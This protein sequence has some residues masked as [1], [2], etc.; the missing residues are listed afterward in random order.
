MTVAAPR[1]VIERLGGV[2]PPPGHLHRLYFGGWW[3][4]ELERARE[5][6][7]QRDPRRRDRLLREAQ[8]R[9]EQSVQL[10][11]VDDQE[12]TR[13]IDA[14]AGASQG[15]QPM[16]ERQRAI[17]ASSSDVCVI[18]LVTTSPLV[19]GVGIDHP[20]EVGFAFLDPHGIAYLP[21]SSIKGTLR[22]A[23]ERLALFG[24]RESKWT[25][26]LV[27]HSFG[28][29]ARA[30]YHRDAGVWRERYRERLAKEELPRVRQLLGGVAA[31][32][33]RRLLREACAEEWPDKLAWRG[34]LCIWDAIPQTDKLGVDVFTP[35][36]PAYYAGKS[37]PTDDQS[38]QP[39]RF[40]VVQP[41]VQLTLHATHR[42]AAPEGHE[43]KELL[44]QAALFAGEQLGFG[45]KTA[46]GY[47]RAKAHTTTR[48]SGAR[49][50]A[51]ESWKGCT[52]TWSAGPGELIANCSRGRAT[53]ARAAA[54]AILSTLPE[55]LRARLKE[56]RK[57]I[58]NLVA[59]VEP[60]GNA[61]RLLALEKEEA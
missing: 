51:H 22:Q 9:R 43:W 1:Y 47:G 14:A 41:G 27:W 30:A 50:P 4:E 18:D 19:T 13:A 17:A 20:N 5:A 48:Q 33:A 54:D 58:K 16:V 36:F 35:H 60:V 34:A 45:A 15:W 32:D 24:E 31:D 29:D 49:A 7:A 52:V 46:A 3:S 10:G 2:N 57:E 55:H 40:L 8:R 53:A 37:A 6:E 26:D 44:K 21:G 12:R 23:A 42:P 28:F 11:S 59:T 61:W 38:P 25:L 39:H 56:R